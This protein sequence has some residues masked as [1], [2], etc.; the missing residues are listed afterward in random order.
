MLPLDWGILT[1]LWFLGHGRN[2]PGHGDVLAD[3]PAADIGPPAVIVT[4]SRSLPRETLVDF[5]RAVAEV[6]RRAAPHRVHR[7]L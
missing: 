7:L 4:P 2:M 5:G 6:R 3:P 1:P